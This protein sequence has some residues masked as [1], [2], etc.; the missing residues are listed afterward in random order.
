MTTALPDLKV[1]VAVTDESVNI[2]AP[3][4]L[5]C[6][7]RPKYMVFTDAMP[8]SPSGRVLNRNLPDRYAG[9]AEKEML[10]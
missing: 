1:G 8:N 4:R 10:P 3:Q 9:L 7:K 5:T 2:F 6:F